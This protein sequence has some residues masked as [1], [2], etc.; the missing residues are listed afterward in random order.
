MRVYV[1]QAYGHIQVYAAEGL[2]D[3]ERLFN[4]VSGALET[5]GVDK[6]LTAAR[7]LLDEGLSTDRTDKIMRSINM[8]AD[9]GKGHESFEYNSFTTV[10]QPR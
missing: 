4:T 2:D 9:I 3:L 8:L 7:V 1:W 6:E 5:W 10:E